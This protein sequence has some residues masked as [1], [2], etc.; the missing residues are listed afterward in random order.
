LRARSIT[1]RV[2]SGSRLLVAT[3]TRSISSLPTRVTAG[4]EPVATFARSMNTRSGAEAASTFIA[5]SAPFPASV[6]V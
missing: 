5:F 6:T 1:T 3:R 2:I 4:A